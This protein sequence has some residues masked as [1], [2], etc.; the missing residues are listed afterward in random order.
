MAQPPAQRRA[1]NP[2]YG[3]SDEPARYSFDWAV[4]DGYSGNN[5]GHSESRDG[6]LTSGS[7]YVQL[8]DGRLQRVTYTVDGY[9]GYQAEVT[10]NGGSL[11]CGGAIIDDRHVIGAS[12]CVQNPGSMHVRVGMTNLLDTTAVFH[13]MESWKEHENY[14]P[15]TLRNDISMITILDADRFVFTNLVGPT[16]LPLQGETIDPNQLCTVSGWGTT[17]SGGTIARNLQYVNVP[18]VGPTEC[19]NDYGNSFDENTMI[20]AG[21]AGKDSCQGDSGGPMIC[22]GTQTGAAQHGIVSWGRGC[23]LDGYPGVYT[24]VAMYIDWINANKS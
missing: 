18:Y 12:H 14:S 17:S 9:G 13:D 16:K 1:G 6:S 2:G 8:P 3:A 11:E 20:C 23:A 15:I 4:N 21:E 19:R 24:K 22:T 10:Y 5:Y 7:Y